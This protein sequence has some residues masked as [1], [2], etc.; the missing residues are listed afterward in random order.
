MGQ[1]SPAGTEQGEIELGGGKL[2]SRGREIAEKGMRKAEEL[3]PGILPRVTERLERVKPFKRAKEEVLGE[4]GTPTGGTP[5]GTGET[6]TSTGSP[7]G[8]G[9]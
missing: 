6:E 2:L 8:V 9:E 5:A 3:R 4:G 7:A 1:A